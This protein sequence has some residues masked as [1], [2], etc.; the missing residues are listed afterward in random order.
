MNAA[1][2]AVA[3]PLD[4]PAMVDRDGRVNEVATQRAQPLERPL[5]VGAGEAAIADDICDQ[6]SHQL[7]GLAHCVPQA[8]DRLAQMPAQVCP[9]AGSFYAE[10]D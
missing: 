6:D 7:S 10:S 8:T 3:G 2:R 9:N 1:Q 4:D 5:L